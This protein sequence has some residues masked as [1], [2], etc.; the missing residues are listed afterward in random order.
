MSPG[1]KMGFPPGDAEKMVIFTNI[2]YF[3]HQ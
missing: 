2:F 3:F 1:D